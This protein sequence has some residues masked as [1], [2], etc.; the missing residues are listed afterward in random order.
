MAKSKTAAPAPGR[1][2]PAE[3]ERHDATW[4]A[5]PHNAS[6]WPGRFG[7][8]P[9]V[10]GDI[11]KKI[12]PE[13]RVH[14]L[15]NDAAHEA[16][17]KKVLRHMAVDLG[18]VSFHRF[19]TDRIWTRD[20]GPI[21]VREGKRQRIAISRFRFNA[22]A[23]YPDWKRDDKVP[24]RAAKKLGLPLLPAVHNGREVVLEGGA[25][26]VNG[27]GTILTTEECLLDAKIQVRNPAFSRADYEAVF[28]ETLG[29][30]TTI[31][32]GKGIA[33]DDTHG[34]VDD[35]ARFVGPR[36]IVLC[37]EDDGGDPNHRVLGENRER[38]E[39]ARLADGTRPEVAFL[40]MPAPLAFNGQRVPASYAN[41]YITNAA[42][43]VPTFNDPNDRIALGILGELI[44]DRPIIG[45]HALDLVWGL[46][47]LHC[48]S[49]QQPAAKA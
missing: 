30:T 17:A 36:T 15:V 9:W 31:W 6:D 40:P 39:A 2:M 48:M 27:A 34:H 24:E 33:G 21:F 49:Q 1:L 42:V 45:I 37:H 47:T 14:L 28:G 16:K 10:Y 19:P 18:Q 8:I 35:L 4:L 25:I 41:F 7:P 29:I 32:L 23:K 13:E 26:D 12:T 5:F 44:R 22:W 20:C 38:L 46:G 43:L 3:W 11:I